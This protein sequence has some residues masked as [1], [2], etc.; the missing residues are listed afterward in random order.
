MQRC[1]RKGAPLFSARFQEEG[2]FQMG[3]GCVRPLLLTER[4]AAHKGHSRALPASLRGEK[5]HHARA[6]GTGPSERRRL[7]LAKRWHSL[8]PTTRAARQD[9]RR[10]GS[11]AR[12]LRRH[13]RRWLSPLSGLLRRRRARDRLACRGTAGSAGAG[14]WAA[15]KRAAEEKLKR[16]RIRE[17][18]CGMI[19]PASPFCLFI[20]LFC[21]AMR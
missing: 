8:S 9:G 6:G 7:A 16:N 14:G 21:A 15:I 18:A 4:R 13:S 10:R 1:S 3:S 17:G 11:S 12:A 20:S 5:E 2:S 19:L